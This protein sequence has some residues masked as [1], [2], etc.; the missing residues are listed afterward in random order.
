MALVVIGFA[1]GVGPLGILGGAFCFVMMV[2]ML[3]RMVGMIRGHG[4]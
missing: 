3:W 4:D 2:M 1:T